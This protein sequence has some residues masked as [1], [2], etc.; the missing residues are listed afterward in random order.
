MPENAGNP[1]SFFQELKRRKVIRVITVY[2]AAAFVIL[3]LVDILSPSLGL[4]TWTLNFILVL[5]CVGFVLAVILS[6]IYDITPEGIEKTK[7]AMEASREVPQ[8]PSGIN[9]W[10]IATIISVVVIVGLIIFHTVGERKQAEDL[11]ILDKS[12]AVLPFENMSDDSEFAH[13]G[14]ALT[15]EIIMQLYKIHEFEVRSRTSIMQY[16]DTEKG[17]PI[18]GEELKVTYLLEGSTQRYEDQVRIRIQLIHA[19]TDDHIW[20]DIFEGEW[21]DIFDI[22][23]NVAKQ[24]AN[25]LKTVL[26]PEEIEH[27]EKKPTENLEA[28]NFYLRGMYYFNLHQDFLQSAENFEKAIQLDS[29]YALAYSYLAQCYQFIARYSAISNEDANFETKKKAKEAILKA[30]EFDPSLGEAHATLGLIM[31]VEDWDIYGPE[32]EFK[33]AI[34]LSPGSSEVYS[35]YAQYLRW[36]GRYDESISL[37]KQ[38]LELDPLNPMSYQWLAVFYSY[39]GQYDKSNQQLKK[40][41]NLNPDFIHAPL[42]YAYNY[43]RMDMFN[44][45]IALADKVISDG[46]LI[47][48][49]MYFSFITWVYAK[50][51]LEDKARKQLEQMLELSKSQYVDPVILAISHAG[52]GENDNAFSCLSRALEIHSGQMIYLKAY[53]DFVFKDLSSDPRYDELLGKIGFEVN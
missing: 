14:D 50:S 18:I 10:K 6:W 13:L 48:D 11:K 31:A 16:K 33:K 29:T 19:S 4:P 51:G 39:S 27:I 30:L 26:S 53:A 38:A 8:K 21:K 46:S 20:G 37:A 25:E 28:Y 23:I 9:A 15:D 1:L 36:L 34:K 44:N 41:L 49:L 45:A 32:S 35:S 5:L 12:I 43:T 22:Q 40:V 52:L 42:L 3:E 47:V 2:A 17:S 24:V 7:P